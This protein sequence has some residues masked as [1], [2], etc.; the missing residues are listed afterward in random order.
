MTRLFFK[1]T[2]FSELKNLSHKIDKKWS[3]L[4]IDLGQELKPQEVKLDIDFVALH[5][6]TLQGFYRSKYK[7]SKGEDA[8]MVSTQFEVSCKI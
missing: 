4:E 6:D 2:L 8:Y 5:S 3:W 7:N 1:F